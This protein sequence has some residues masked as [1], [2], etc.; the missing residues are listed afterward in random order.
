MTTPNPDLKAI[1]ESL[2]RGSVKSLARYESEGNWSAEE[3]KFHQSVYI[4]QAL[5]AIT[6]WADKRFEGAVGPESHGEHCA[7][8]IPAA[9][10]TYCTCSDRVVD[11]N[12][13]RQ[14]QR[15]RWDK[16]GGID[17]A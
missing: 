2:Q 1:L 4:D 9:E 13:L 12:A 10:T 16:T 17:A 3:R 15:Q 11:E 14:E 6:E 5:Q 8:L 7:T